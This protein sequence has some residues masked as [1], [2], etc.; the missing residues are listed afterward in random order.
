MFMNLLLFL[1]FIYVVFLAN[2]VRQIRD[3]SQKQIEDLEFSVRYLNEKISNLKKAIENSD[4]GESPSD[5]ASKPQPTK[6]AAKEEPKP[7]TLVAKPDLPE[8]K[9][10]LV[11][12][13]LPSQVATSK[14]IVKAV[15]SIDEPNTG[16]AAANTATPNEVVKSPSA[17][18][19]PVSELASAAGGGAGGA[20]PETPDL[21]ERWRQF[22]DNV[23]WEQFTGTKLTAWLSGVA[24]FVGAGF[25]VKYSID[26]DLISAIMRLVIGAVIGLGMVITSGY[27]ARGKYDIMRQSFAS[28]GV[29]VLYAVFFA[30]TLHYEYL[31]KPVGFACL[32]V[33]SAAAFALALFHKGIAVSVLGAVGAYLTPLLVNTGQGSLVS[34][35]IYLS[36]VNVGLYQ[37][38]KRLDSSAL[39]LFATA[40]T[41]LSLGMATIAASPAPESWQIT[42]AWVINLGVFASILDLFK[43]KGS[44]DSFALW[45]MQILFAATAATS[46]YLIVGYKGS[47]ALVVLAA[48]AGALVILAFRNEIW[49]DRVIP[50]GSL[51]YVFAFGWTL[52]RFNAQQG[53]TTFFAFFLYGFFAGLGPVILIYRHGIKPAFLKW[54]RVFPVAIAL[55]SLVVVALNP[56][57][58]YLFWPMAVA[59]QVIAIVVSLAF[60]AVFQVAILA[61]ILL[62]SAALWLGSLTVVS[63]S[64]FAIGLFLLVVAFI[65]LLSIV[66][67]GRNLASWSKTL[68]I[69]AQEQQLVKLENINEWLAVAPIAGF[70]GLI[71]LSFYMVRPLNAHPGMF[72]WLCFS[73]LALIF[74]YKTR[75][76]AMGG[77]VLA[78]A[79]L[80]QAVWAFMPEAAYEINFASALWSGSLF[81]LALA[82]PFAF[83]GDTARWKKTWAGW[84]LFEIIQSVYFLYAADMLW[85]RDL[86][87][88]LP[89]SLF[90]L[91]ALTVAVLV[92]RLHGKSERNTI[93][94]CHGA[95]MLFY[96]SATPFLLLENGWFGLVLVF[97][98]TALLWL[99][100]RVEHPGLPKASTV[101]APIGLYFMLSFL[102]QMKSP[103]SMVILNP[104]VLSVFFALLA[105]GWAVRL[106]TKPGSDPDDFNTGTYFRWLFVITGF[107]LVNLVIADI[108]AGSAF[109]PGQRP[110]KFIPQGDLLQSILY[111]SFWA[112]FGAVLWV[113]KKIP[114][115]MRV[116]GLILLTLSATWLVAFPFLNGLMVA[117]MRP[118]V[119]LGLLAYL[120]IMFILL[121]LFLKQPYT[122]S[123]LS[124]KNLFLSMLLILL[125]LC[126]KVIKSTVFQ[127]G[128]PL[129]FF[130]T[131]TASMAL[132]SAAGWIIYGLLMH[133]WPKRLDRPF[134]IAGFVLMMLGFLR[135]AIFPFSYKVEFGL[136][137]PILNYPTLLHAFC[138][139]L[140]GWLVW[141]KPDDKWPFASLSQKN[142]WGVIL[143][144]TVFYVLNIQ[145]ASAFGGNQAFSLLTRGRFVHQ[146]GYSLGWLIYAISLLVVGIKWNLVR[147]RQAS[148]I[149]IMITSIKI[150]FK[151]LWDL[152]NLYR[153]AAFIGL[154][155][156]SMLVS[157]L[158][159]RFL[160]KTEGEKT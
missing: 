135:A 74:A 141:R 56:N 86:A 26:H 27:F 154:A 25:F 24:L 128:M 49:V 3:D 37:V 5:E 2:R 12:P 98:A 58:S 127:P 121:F 57:M 13:P 70:Y 81:I 48:L 67:V 46:L 59:V 7:E 42:L 44:K 109:E 116:F 52:L 38:I 114:Y 32:V 16:A 36:I 101:L 54:F 68:R 30:A 39:L 83:Y 132:T 160:T 149:F 63:A 150:F 6:T 126:I 147:A 129:D 15:T 138:L 84:A 28:G 53:P 35:V 31:D 142:F 143:A 95:T 61:L 18:P 20:P 103:E 140:L 134:R 89:V 79:A 119:N 40:G 94:A 69:N 96:F 47:G 71:A 151:D 144:T 152:G 124:I 62:L 19:S 131:R 91:K 99:N 133:L 104:A 105:L 88:W 45:S 90:L 100:K 148:L 145:I 115:A 146:L 136:M 33:V 80:P 11:P 4:K 72:V 97:E 106:R 122:R 112:L 21:T 1:L 137:Q 108:F 130:Q 158:Y 8:K 43:P 60:G 55:L 50:I 9:P 17:T 34:M 139:A 118:F 87:G 76:A 64:I 113:Q 123:S 107:F 111:V 155:A 117:Q 92:K 41:S 110:F 125:F 153:V 14:P 75:F 157:Y 65:L 120:P 82:L 66:F 51:S 85:S 156:V 22:K 73:V 159:Q 102:N 10:P 93:L 23:D 29:G 78:C 77:A